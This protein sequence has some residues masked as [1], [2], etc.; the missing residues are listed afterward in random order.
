[1]K[2]PIDE[3]DKALKLACEA[4]KKGEL[5]VYPTDTLYGVGA[6]ATSEKAV[7][8]VKQAKGRDAS[9]PISI[10]CSDLLMI[11]K[12][13]E[14]DE[15]TKAILSSILP[16]PFTVILKKKKGLAS[17][18]A[19]GET[20][21]VRVPRYFFLLALIRECG[22]PITGTSANES[23]GKDPCSLTDVP[24]SIKQAASVLIDGG[25]CFFSAP[26]TVVDMTGKELKVL[27][28][29]AGKL[30]FKGERSEAG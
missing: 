15:K 30:E 13:C 26:S 16:G 23:G 27:R 17:S 10:I 14:V 7:E 19:P 3:Y 29:G 21:G 1:M 5:I 9:K 11:E 28:K 20:I 8:K 4:L 25:K 24:E 2:I 22:F 12:H 6:D 18:L